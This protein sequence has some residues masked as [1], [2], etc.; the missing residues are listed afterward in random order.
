[1]LWVAPLTL[2]P[3]EEGGIEETR[4]GFVDAAG[5]MVVPQR[6]DSYGYCP[7]A[8]GRTAFVMLSAAGHKDEVVDLTG[9]LIRRLP[10]DSTE[11]GGTDHVILTHPI[12]WEVGKYNSGLLNLTTGAM[13]VPIA[14]DRHID[15]LDANTVN[16]SDPSGEYFL[17][18][19]TGKKTPHKG[20][21]D[22]E[23]LP[24]DGPA[25]LAA[26]QRTVGGGSRDSKLGFLN[27]SGAWVVPPTYDDATGFSQG[28][29]AVKEG[30]KATFVDASLKPVGQTWS[31][32]T[33]VN[34]PQTDAVVA[35]QVTR[36]NEQGLLGPDL[37]VIV[38]PSVATIECDWQSASAC[39]IVPASGSPSW[40]KLPEGTVTPMPSGFTMVL[41]SSFLIEGTTGED[42]VTRRVYA[43]ATGVSVALSNATDC[44][45]VGT[46]WVACKGGTGMTPA[47]VI[48]AAGRVTGFSSAQA[49][50]DPAPGS[51]NAY[52]W[53]A[54]GLY[55]GF[56]DATGTWRYRQSRFTQLED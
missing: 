21:L 54:S 16:V 2:S 5:K 36:G 13:V 49:V 51:S 24:G 45:G 7:D 50:A 11:C 46:L 32:I 37:K 34:D 14:K 52:Y 55:E 22:T 15:V 9:K 8:K 30:D 41:S 56:V 42:A 29:A 48:D 6:Y 38:A 17:D 12:D 27:R 4:Y 10:T 26:A 53:V 47:V 43:V 35:Y 19:A 40:V 39:S 25:Y 28:Y 3:T 33:S 20:W 1:M 23:V 18:L 44:S 31:E